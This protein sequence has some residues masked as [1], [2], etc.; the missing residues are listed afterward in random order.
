MPAAFGNTL[1]EINGNF[2]IGKYHLSDGSLIKVDFIKI[3]VERG[4]AWSVVAGGLA[5]NRLFVSTDLG[6][7]EEYNATTGALINADFLKRGNQAEPPYG[8]QWPAIPSTGIFSPTPNGSS[9]A[10]G[11]LLASGNYLY[12]SKG[13]S[14]WYV[15]NIVTGTLVSGGQ[16]GSPL[17]GDAFAVLGNYGYEMFKGGTVVELLAAYG[18]PVLGQGRVTFTPPAGTTPSPMQCGIAASGNYL[19]I[20]NGNPGTVS[21]YTPDGVLVNPNFIVTG[22]DFPIAALYVA[23]GF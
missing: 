10:Y 15:Y 17:Y 23:P 13:P 1:F 6:N 9:G 11:P 3:P 20:A 22:N 16:G 4:T 7:V 18:A 12:V 2:T 19:F 21:Q 5:A 8:I 14:G